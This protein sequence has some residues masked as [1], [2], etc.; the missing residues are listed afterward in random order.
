MYPVDVYDFHLYS[1]APW[2]EAN[3][4]GTGLRL[5]KPWFVGEA[6]CASGN[7]RCTYNSTT[8]SS[9]DRRWLAHMAG[10]PMHS[11]WLVGATVLYLIAGACWLPVVWMQIRMRNWANAAIIAG[12]ETLP[13]GYWRYLRMWTALGVPAF[14][15]LVIV[16]WLMI[17]KPA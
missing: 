17:A 16:F 1:D 3:R 12:D 11:R 7:I 6:G 8:V 13:P 15:A 9:V 5:P 2:D 10:Y 4:W 14:I